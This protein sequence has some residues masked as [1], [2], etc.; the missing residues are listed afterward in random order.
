M[1]HDNIVLLTY[2]LTYVKAV[3]LRS[4]LATRFR[5]KSLGISNEKHS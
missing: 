4:K 3:N 1:A 5:H 2:L